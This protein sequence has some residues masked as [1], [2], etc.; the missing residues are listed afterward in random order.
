M[1]TAGSRNQ[2]PFL[3]MGPSL[4]EVPSNSLTV[5]CQQLARRLSH[6]RSLEEVPHADLSP[7]PRRQIRI[8]D[9]GAC[10]SDELEERRSVRI[11]AGEPQRRGGRRAR[12]LAHA[13]LGV[14]QV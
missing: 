8:V 7:P 13:P 11:E 2:T 12:D 5:G 10:W 3:T 14:E 1:T 4:R 6:C 9:E